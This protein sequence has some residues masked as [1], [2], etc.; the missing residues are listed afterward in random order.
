MI[1]NKKMVE[2]TGLYGHIWFK[3]RRSRQA[4]MKIALL[5]MFII[6]ATI[7]SPLN[8][9]TS[10]K[11]EFSSDDF[12]QSAGELFKQNKRASAKQ[13]QSFIK[14][15][16]KDRLVPEAEFMVGECFFSLDPT[17]SE[18]LKKFQSVVNRYSSSKQAESA[19]L[20]IAEI[21]YNR[22]D[23]SKALDS[24]EKAE[25]RYAKGYLQYERLL[26]KAQ[27]YIILQRFEEAEKI[28]TNLVS[29]QQAY[30]EDERFNYIF[31][32]VNYQLGKDDLAL[33]N[34]EEVDLPEAL[35]FSS[36][37]LVRLKKP[38]LGIEKLKDLINKYPETS[39]QERVNYL[40]GEAFFA[41]K[42]YISAIHSYERFLQFY[43][44]SSLIG[45]AIYKIASSYLEKGDYLQARSSFQSF[46][47]TEPKSEFAPRAIYLIG[48]S[49]L[50]E[51]R[52]KE[53]CF[54]YG[55]MVSSYPNDFY[56]PNAQF[57]LGWC[58]FNLEGFQQ[59][60]SS[61]IKFKQLYPDHPLLP[62]VELLLGN[63]LTELKLY[64]A[65]SDAYQR[66]IDQ[67]KE[68]EIREVALALMSRA[69]YLGENYAALVSGCR[70]LLN[71]FSP[72]KSPW[73]LI[74]YLYLAEGY[75]KQGM[76]N[77]AIELY[78]LIQSIYPTN[79]LLIYAQEGLAWANFLNEDYSEAQKIREK[80]QNISQQKDL[81]EGLVL[82]N[83]Y[84]L[85]NAFFNQK[86][87]LKAIDIFDVFH[88]QN[89][90]HYLA[91]KAA[92]NGGL[93]Y[94][95]LEYFAQ[96]IE[97]W[98]NMAKN[99]PDA[100]ETKQA[101]WKV[102]DT[103][104]RAQLYDKAI[105]TYKRIIEHY[106]KDNK[107]SAR[108]HLCIAQCYYNSKNNVLAIQSLKELI[109][110][111]PLEPQAYEALDFL[112]GLLEV[113]DSKESALSALKD[114]IKSL[115]RSNP[116]AIEAQFRL[117]RSFFEDKN[118]SKATEMLERIISELLKSTRFADSNYY[119]AESYY[120]LSEFNKAE[121]AY[122]RFIDNFPEDKRAIIAIFHLGS[123]Q[124]KGEKFAEAA[125][126]FEKLVQ[127][128]PD[129]EY[130]TGAM[131]NTILAYR[132]LR[133]WE[134]AASTLQMY[135]EK[136][137]AAAK[138]S[139]MD[140]ELATIY[141][142]QNQYLK[143]IE[144]LQAIR[145]KM[146]RRTETWGEITFRIAGNYMTIEE[147][148][149]GIGE[150]QKLV[151]TSSSLPGGWMFNAMIKMGEYYEKNGEMQKALSLYEKIY[152]KSEGMA[153]K[154][155]WFKAI[156]SRIDAIRAEIKSR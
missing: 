75:L 4:L 66:V 21:Y 124:F 127:N 36:K 26:L 155:S 100:P 9:L 10:S 30:E 29:K 35:L 6:F 128:Y 153:K 134:K 117:A 147:E 41:A 112:T 62:E 150:Y 154:P 144:I 120:Q 48:E 119:L 27:C 52:F 73:R 129:C 152:K 138:S 104:F 5:T 25:T 15:Y 34:L 39:L 97:T 67:T 136:Y 99:Y 140:I 14:L 92:L 146:D 93:C 74:T 2:I 55:D 58:Y 70:Y 116:L 51:E 143:A 114:I 46:L 47:Q 57:K 49:F 118:Y 115:G 43:S 40:I 98:E 63:T 18:A 3:D 113:P 8:G 101:L 145:N 45:P 85:A 96:A 31:G 42:D 65:A 132:K 123:A 109:E 84:E 148:E 102:A 83:R 90:K 149:K 151:S 78:K 12:F 103:Y 137:P 59:A 23:Y 89:P 108:A 54:A 22:K 20:R 79:P 141:E 81:P 94:Y 121:L 82:I 50:R 32:L 69:N 1:L 122:K 91:A 131:Y 80:I 107:E 16:P 76:H 86:K 24:L 37:S 7:L 71:Q 105:K 88:K 125:E 110:K 13:F 28:L 19:S 53:A 72:S 17:S 106:V 68:V 130:S 64:M 11:P 87:Y 156:K 95:Q 126:T 33:K 133:K 56:S 61:L 139:G 44:Q 142:E 111:F 38:L 60:K 135:Q 77:E